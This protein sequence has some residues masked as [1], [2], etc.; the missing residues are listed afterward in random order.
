MTTKYRCVAV[1]DDRLIL[2]LVS[3]Y[4]QA[5]EPGIEVITFVDADEALTFLNRE[6]VD[7]VITDIHMPGLDGL[8][9]IRRFREFDSSTPIVVVSAD[10]DRKET[11]L[12]TGAN[13]FV[14]KLSLHRDFV[15]TLRQ[16]LDERHF[17]AEIGDLTANVVCVGGR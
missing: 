15:P 1:D 13:V 4:L 2:D 10:T 11:I 14:S 3:N 9:F 17:L 16:M 5:A 6:H 8:G 7:L 12:E